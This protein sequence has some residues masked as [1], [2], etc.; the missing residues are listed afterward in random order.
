[1]L[2]FNELLLTV[3]PVIRVEGFNDFFIE[4]PFILLLIIINKKATDFIN[5][6][7]IEKFEFY[8]INDYL[9]KKFQFSFTW[10]FH[11]PIL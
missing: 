11:L 7:D 5:R 2:K 1:M 9:N 4:L 8:F 6:P 3:A 10:I